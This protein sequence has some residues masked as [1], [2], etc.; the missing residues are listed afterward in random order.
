MFNLFKNNKKKKQKNKN[1]SRRV[2]IGT[3]LQTRDESLLSGK[4]YKKPGYENKGKYRRV[5]VV[6]SNREDDLAVVKLTTSNKATK[7]GAYQEGKAKYKPV[8]ETRTNKNKPIRVGKDFKKN[9]K[10]RNVA[11]HE[12]NQIKKDLFVKSHTK[13]KNTARIRQLKNRK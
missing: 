11:K 2:G 13:E 6:D 1:I 3:T 5:V 8:L 4:N 9:R 12:V 7:V 10:S